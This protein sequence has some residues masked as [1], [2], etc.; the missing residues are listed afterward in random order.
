MWE[1]IN[2]IDVSDSAWKVAFLAAAG[3]LCFAIY[4]GIR[5]F[6][7]RFL[8]IMDRLTDLSDKMDKRIT[9]VEQEHKMNIERFKKV[10]ERFEKNDK[11]IDMLMST[12]LKA[13]QR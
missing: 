4:H 2:K 10:D 3:V 8:K 9:L 12:L 6:G 13:T 1:F 7:Q 5:F 11:H